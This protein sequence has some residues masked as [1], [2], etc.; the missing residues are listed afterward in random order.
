M[1]EL[2]WEEPPRATNYVDRVGKQAEA[3][4]QLR[5]RP[6]E[7]AVVLVCE[8]SSVASSMAY[9]I[10]NGTRST[11]TPA[12]SFE[13]KARTKEGEHRVYARYVGGESDE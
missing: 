7:W 12:G 9:A 10:R 13:A 1:S 2:T 11:W 5:E 8:S 4:A 6:G 3:A